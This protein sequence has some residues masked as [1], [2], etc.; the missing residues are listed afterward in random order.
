MKDY[1]AAFHDPARARAYGEKFRRGLF[2]RWT[3]A[4]ERACLAGA[5]REA[6]R[7]GE[8]DLVLD[9]PCGAGRWKGP[10]ASAGRRYLGLDLSRPMVELARGKGGGRGEAF[11][12]ASAWALPLRDGGADLVFCV[13]L[14]HHV[15]EEGEKAALVKE[16]CRVA[17]KALVVTFLDGEAPKQRIHRWKRGLLGRP[18]RRP[19]WTRRALEAAAREGGFRLVRYWRVSPWFSGQT[20]ALF[21]REGGA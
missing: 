19:W 13:R 10:L 6:R 17:G 18:V 5:L 21:E 14:L 9:A 3:H 12:V 4:R 20:W 7:L 16:L 2:R 11:A 15:R 1:S 8:A